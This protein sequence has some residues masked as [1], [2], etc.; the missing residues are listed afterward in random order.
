MN[1]DSLVKLGRTGFQA[2]IVPLKFGFCI[3]IIVAVGSL[4]LKNQYTSDVR[5]LPKDPRSAG[6]SLGSLAAAAA[7]FGVGGGGGEDVGAAYIDIVKSRRVS[8]GILT[9]S[10]VFTDRSWYFGSPRNHNK[11]LLTYLDVSNIDKGVKALYEV[12]DVQRDL[13]SGLIT[14]SASTPSPELS[15]QVV[16]TATR[17]LEEYIQVHSQ[18]QAGAKAEFATTRLNE[19]REEALVA[20]E[21]LK[22][23]LS[24]NRNYLSSADPDVRL[25]GSRLEAELQLRR[26]LVGTLALSREQALLDQKDNTPILNILDQGQLPVEKSKP[27]RGLMVV[28]SFAFGFFCLIAWQNREWIK[29]H[30]MDTE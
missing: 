2:I 21:A 16:R 1:V 24:V 6:G 22:R 30:F 19:A 25:K 12:L 14:L 26:Q 10:Y 29:K 15:Q 9:Q 20:E 11:T 5:L 28:A 8:E 7:A 3:A 4:F 18:S 23:F 17:L 27:K 13:K